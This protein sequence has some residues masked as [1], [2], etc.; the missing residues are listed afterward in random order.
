M[1]VLQ[2]HR[3]RGIDLIAP[4]APAPDQAG[5]AQDTQMLGDRGKRSIELDDKPPDRTLAAM[6]QIENAPAVG[7][8]DGAEHI[9]AGLQI[10][11]SGHY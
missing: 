10:Q 5:L 7:I 6:Q 11:H 2:R 8:G 4:F 1:N 9:A 3:V